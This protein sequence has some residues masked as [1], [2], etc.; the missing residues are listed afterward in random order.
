M[1][2]RSALFYVG[3]LLV[4]VAVIYQYRSNMTQLLQQFTTGTTSRRAT[5]KEEG[6]TSRSSQERQT[7]VPT[8][9]GGRGGSRESKP[10][11]EEEF[12]NP[13]FDPDKPSEELR[14]KSGTRLFTK[15]ELAA[16]GPNGPL[17]PILVAIYGR[18]FDVSKAEQYYGPEGG[19]KFFAGI[20]GSRAFVTGE[21]NEEGLIDDLEGFSPLQIGEIDG[22]AKFY[23]ESYT[24]AGKLIGR[25]MITQYVYCTYNNNN[26]YVLCMI[27]SVCF[28]SLLYVYVY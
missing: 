24:F 19:Y 23:E 14:S 15:N 28:F 1:A 25:C 7:P 20:D 2:S 5:E 16:H 17:K 6:K 3:V 11:E 4:L 22:W 12:Y 18:V 10:A 8:R 21:F 9:H 13:P 26:V 27:Y